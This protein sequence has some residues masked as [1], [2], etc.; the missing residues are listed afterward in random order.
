MPINRRSL[1]SDVCRNAHRSVLF[2]EWQGKNAAKRREYMAEWRANNRGWLA[3]WNRQNAES[4]RAQKAAA[5]RRRRDRS[6]G[7]LLIRDS[8]LNRAFARQGGRCAYC[9]TPASAEIRS[10]DHVVPLSR[11]GT[12]SIGNLLLACLP[13]NQQKHTKTVTEWR[14][15][16]KRMGMPDL[17]SLTV[18]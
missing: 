17:Q 11:G 10:W 7:A 8:D 5:Q 13:C 16:R 15:W 1:C 18:L 2:A 3:D 14:V 4:R 9:G 6:G 12:D